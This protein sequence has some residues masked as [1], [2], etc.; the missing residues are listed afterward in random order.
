MKQIYLASPLGF[1]ASTRVFMEQMEQRLQGLAEIANPWSFGTIPKAERAEV[2]AISD[3]A[4]HAERI[5][6]LNHRIAAAN[7]AAI[8]RADALVAVLDGV[9]VDSGTAAEIGYAA[10]LGKRAWGIRT[11]FRL[12]GENHGAIVNLQV[13]YWIEASGGSIARTLEDLV[14]SMEAAL[15]STD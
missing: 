5:H 1:A 15:T 13:Q 11:D 14:A 12:T 6:A 10:A 7:E 9:D 8:Q 3:R 4:Q 2:E